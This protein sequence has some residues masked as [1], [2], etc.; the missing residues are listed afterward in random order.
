[1][2][3]CMADGHAAALSRADLHRKAQV[4]TSYYHYYTSR[5]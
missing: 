1:M 2:Q 5:K 3:V 4:S